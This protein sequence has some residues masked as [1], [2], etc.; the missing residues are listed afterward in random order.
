MKPKKT[1]Q[2]SFL[3]IA[4]VGFSFTSCQK[5]K[6]NQGNTD[7]SSMQ[8][9]TTDEINVENAMNDATTDADAAMSINGGQEKSTAG[10]PCNA[11]IDSTSRINDSITLFITYNGLNCNGTRNRTGKIEI[12]KAV[13]THWG[14]AG[15]TVIY[16]FINYTV[17]RVATGKSV[18]LNGTKTFKNVSGGYIRQLGFAATSIVHRIKGA[19]QATFDNG[20]TRTWNVA[21]QV[22]FTG[23][24][25]HLLMTIDGLGSVGEY[26]N[27]ITWGTNRNDETFYT[28][29]T[30]SIVHK[31]LC[32]WDPVSG[33]KIH[34]IPSARKS[35]TI[36]F[37]YD[38]DNQPI[39]R[40]ECPTKYRFDWQRN[41]NSGT[42]YVLLP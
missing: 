27:L 8:Q 4:L 37:G 11:T 14:Q 24:Q 36:T 32:N 9:L 38:N 26:T 21:R 19:I 22:T 5:D 3:L 30:Q 39:T 40:D 2:L 29:I 1:I 35:A 16:K 10:W 7:T 33:I 6:L 23:T 25:N 12:K 17:T 28:Q 41:G 31:E 13:R 34:Q 18:S 15:A 20:T 42:I